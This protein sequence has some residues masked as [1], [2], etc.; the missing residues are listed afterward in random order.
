MV[1]PGLHPYVDLCPVFGRHVTCIV[2]RTQSI[3]CTFEW[4]ATLVSCVVAAGSVLSPEND[5]RCWS[6]RQWISRVSQPP[7]AS[8]IIH[9]GGLGYS[10]IARISMRP[11][12]SFKD[13]KFPAVSQNQ[14]NSIFHLPFHLL[15]EMN[16]NRTITVALSNY[17]TERFH[18]YN[19]GMY[20][21]KAKEC[22]AFLMEKSTI[23]FPQ[24][25]IRQIQV[26]N[27]RYSM[28]IKLASS[29][30]AWSMEKKVTPL[31]SNAILGLDGDRDATVQRLRQPGIARSKR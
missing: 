7:T 22:Y 3:T 30:N 31:E 17:V 20:A 1:A 26:R 13:C 21:A 23:K 8:Q 25:G 2:V 4:I 11:L 19:G 27:T 9:Q 18:E 24:C 15:E 29:R 14:Q 6:A 5:P 10:H 28:E 12:S 16:E